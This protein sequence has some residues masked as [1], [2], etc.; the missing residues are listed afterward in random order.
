MPSQSPGLNTLEKMQN[1]RIVLFSDT[2]LIQ[3]DL[4]CGGRGEVPKSRRVRGDSKLKS[5][6]C[7]PEVV[8][9]ESAFATTQNV[10]TVI[11]GNLI[12]RDFLHELEVSD[13]ST[14]GGRGTVG[15]VKMY[16]L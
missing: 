3:L 13:V 10:E 8:S 9:N 6:S 2:P 12:H 11:D 15:H 4:I 7:L 5:L 1:D 14:R 16:M